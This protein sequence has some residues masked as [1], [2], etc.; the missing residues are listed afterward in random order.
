MR[1]RKYLTA[2]D[3]RRCK[4]ERKRE[5]E[6]EKKSMDRC[7][8]KENGSKKMKIE[9][10]EE[11]KENEQEEKSEKSE[12]SLH[13]GFVI[14][15]DLLNMYVTLGFNVWFNRTECVRTGNDGD[16]ILKIGWIFY[17]DLPLT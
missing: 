14:G 10:K 12:V 8:V 1:N 17:L 13:E 15:S 7:H 4:I 2:C 16:N 3:T 6:N 9:E 5:D 11:K